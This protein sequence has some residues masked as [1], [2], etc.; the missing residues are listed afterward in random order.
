[1]VLVCYRL[2]ADDVVEPTAL[3]PWCSV[4]GQIVLGFIPFFAMKAYRMRKDQ[5]DVMLAF[6]EIPSE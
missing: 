4:F 5:I 1:M 3:N 2:L 6:N